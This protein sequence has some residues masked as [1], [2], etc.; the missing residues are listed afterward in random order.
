MSNSRENVGNIIQSIKERWE[1][2]RIRKNMSVYIG[3]FCI[4]TD[5]PTDKIN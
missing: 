4:L 1:K 3:T 2:N 5:R